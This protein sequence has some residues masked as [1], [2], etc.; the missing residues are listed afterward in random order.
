MLDRAVAREDAA[1][2]EVV[3][4]RVGREL[5]VAVVEPVAIRLAK[6]SERSS[7][8]RTSTTRSRV[9]RGTRRIVTSTTS[10]RGRSRRR[11][12]RTVGVLS[13]LQRDELARGVD[14][15]EGLHV[16]RR[17]ARRS[18]RARARS[19]QARR[20]WR[21]GRRRSASAGTPTAHRRRAAASGTR[22]LGPLD[23]RLHDDR[24]RLARPTTAT[25]SSPRMSRS[26][27]RSRTAARPWRAGRRRWRRAASRPRRADRVAERRRRSAQG[28][29]RDRRL[30]ELRV[31]VVD[32]NAHRR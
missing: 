22:E 31:D 15:R 10:R 17:K 24:P 27:P 8:S 3:T 21:A 1:A 9:R 29:P 18:G 5:E 16:G 7:I 14:E 28:R 20:R 25:P 6:S 23:S 30:V 32:E 12:A 2:Q 19:R 4:R 11:R 26:S 13:R